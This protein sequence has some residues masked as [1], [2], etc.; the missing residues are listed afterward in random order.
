MARSRLRARY[1]SRFAASAAVAQDKV[2]QS[3]LVAQQD[4]GTDYLEAARQRLRARFLARFPLAESAPGWE[5]FLHQLDAA[6]PE[7]IVSIEVEKK[8]V[9]DAPEMPWAMPTDETLR[10][11]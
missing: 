1:N 9:E 11:V 3:V 6:A 8:F 4:A 10:R 7:E 5:T 2:T